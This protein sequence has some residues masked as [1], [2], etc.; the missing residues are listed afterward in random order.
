MTTHFLKCDLDAFQ[1]VHDGVKTYELRFNDRAFAVGD[2]L[3]LK[4]TRFAGAEMRIDKPLRY[5]GR[6]AVRC[7]SHV[8]S[9]YGL[10]N[11]WVI[12]SFEM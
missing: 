11:G 5:T 1:A 12:L 6:E 2:V 4:E 8:L 3:R 9:G 10:V 7:V